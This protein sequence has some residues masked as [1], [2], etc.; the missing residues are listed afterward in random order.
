MIT[1]TVT[2][3]RRET[4]APAGYAIAVASVLLT[5]EAAVDQLHAVIRGEIPPTVHSP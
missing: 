3:G 4:S 1:R 5:K 2:A